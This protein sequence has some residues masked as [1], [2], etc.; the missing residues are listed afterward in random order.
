MDKTTRSR[1]VSLFIS[2]FSGSVLL[3]VKD[4][5]S[6]S[7]ELRKGRYE[8]VGGKKYFLK[9]CCELWLMKKALTAVTKPSPPPP[10][11]GEEIRQHV[12]STVL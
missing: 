6:G 7:T 10:V 5:V 1:T 9:R 11:I 12:T 3:T 8:K 4:P 2:G